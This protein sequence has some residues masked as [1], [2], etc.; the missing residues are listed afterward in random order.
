[1]IKTIEE[2][3]EEQEEVLQLMLT[4]LQVLE[5][6]KVEFPEIRI[7]DYRNQLEILKNELLRVNHS[8]PVEK[9]DEQIIKMR[10]LHDGI[11]EVVKVR[12]HHHF[13]DK[14]KGF[15]IGAIVLLLI[16]AMAVGIAVSMWKENGRLNENSVKFRVIRQ[17]YPT[18]A[19][20]ADTTYHRD[21]EV[22]KV[23]T[24]KL[25]AEQLAVAQAE[26]VA[27]EKTLDSKQKKR[28]LKLLHHGLKER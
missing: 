16:C 25:E 27:R 8:Y 7:P 12:H 4:K 24:E 1:M 11:P 10:T 19:Y 15:I 28:K 21:P 5:N 26:A 2:R 6:R 23:L 14:S 3:L 20:W 18:I 9:I 17:G 22:I 13:E